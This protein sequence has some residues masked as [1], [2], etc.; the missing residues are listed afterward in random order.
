[1]GKSERATGNEQ[2]GK[3]IGY[4]GLE[5]F[6]NL[7]LARPDVTTFPQEHGFG[8]KQPRRIDPVG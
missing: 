3:S 8:S 5:E 1:M 2:W 7:Q 6:K 4:H